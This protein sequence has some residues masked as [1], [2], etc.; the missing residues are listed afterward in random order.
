MMDSKVLWA[1]IDIAPDL[2]QDRLEYYHVK[3][4]DV[5]IKQGDLGDEAFIVWEGT[6]RVE[7]E[8]MP[9]G[10]PMFIRT[11]SLG[12]VVGELS[13][14]DQRPRSATVTAEEDSILIRFSHESLN[15]LL[16]S[17]PEICLP[18]LGVM[19]ERIRATQHSLL[20][21]YRAQDDDFYDAEERHMQTIIAIQNQLALMNN[22]LDDVGA[23]LGPLVDF[24]SKRSRRFQDQL[25]HAQKGMDEVNALHQHLH[26][27]RVALGDVHPHLEHI[28]LYAF[29][30]ELVSLNRKR[31]SRR[32]VTLKTA[33]PPDL[34]VI[35]S[36]PL[37]LMA[38]LQ[39]LTD[40]AFNSI[41]KDG[42][43][44]YTVHLI[45]DD[46]LSVTVYDNG[47]GLP[48][49]ANLFGLNVQP[50]GQVNLGLPFC[51]QA[52]KHLGGDI[53][54]EPSEMWAGTRMVFTLLRDAA[55]IDI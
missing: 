4:G 16:T 39:E 22:A 5:V 46:Y 8:M 25:D 11:V 34:P 20:A 7:V 9:Q 6:L 37:L 43:I 24:L 27:F 40:N 14:L 30:E 48:R 10:V 13:L 47:A 15:H 32:K 50:N 2:M 35:H 41:K 29:F 44:V 52:V 53:W 17:Q 38:T 36:D 51:Y 31:A 18:L 12:E 21:Y 49:E 3:E 26:R 19:T 33:L 55:H 54:V 1:L 23:Q 42:E 28:D 45:D